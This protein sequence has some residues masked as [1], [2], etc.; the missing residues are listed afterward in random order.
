MP[1]KGKLS[2]RTLYTA[3]EYLNMK[4]YRITGKLKRELEELE[5][6][7]EKENGRRNKTV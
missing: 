7:Y 5:R 6:K 3:E 4:D 1:R 2:G